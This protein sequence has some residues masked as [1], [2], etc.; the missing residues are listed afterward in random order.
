MVANDDD[1]DDD[2]VVDDV[3]E[4]IGS[5]LSLSLFFFPPPPSSF[6]RTPLSLSLSPFTFA[7]GS[8]PT[9]QF[10]SSIGSDFSYL[11][12][13]SWGFFLAWFVCVVCGHFTGAM[14]DLQAFSWRLVM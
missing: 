1:D 12:F 5:I 2:D 11:S 3:V 4:M 13:V 6:F 7:L 14:S 9:L 10:T 8:T